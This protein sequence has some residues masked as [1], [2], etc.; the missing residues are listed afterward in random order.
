M[1]LHKNY[2]V[3]INH[4]E[5][6]VIAGALRA[7]RLDAL[8]KDLGWGIDGTQPTLDKLINSFNIHVQQRSKQ[9]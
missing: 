7:V 3:E 1:K 9:G 4:E 6:I 2:T 8:A 5:A